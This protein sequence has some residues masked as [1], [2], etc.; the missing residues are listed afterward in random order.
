MNT[1]TFYPCANDNALRHAG[2]FLRQRGVQIALQSSEHVTHLLLAVPSFDDKGNLRGGG[3]PA[4]LLGELPK[5]I[6]I[7]GGGLSHP[8]LENYRR[9]DL[10]EDAQYLAK[11]AAITAHCA[12]RL[13]MENLPVTLSETPVLVIGW[14]RIGKCL[15]PLLRN[16]GAEVTVAARNDADLAMLCALGYRT[17]DSRHLGCSLIRYRLIIN[18]V[19]NIVIPEQSRNHCRADALLIDLASTRGIEGDGVLHAR[20]LPGRMAPETAGKLIAASA[21][22]KAKTEGV[23]CN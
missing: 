1:M 18:T 23:P 17:E 10:L 7:I 19:P 12:L 8:V 20:G 15:A 9:I 21:L 22:R 4:R 3:N 5:D 16:L 6:I 2:H 11:N 13:A 14:G